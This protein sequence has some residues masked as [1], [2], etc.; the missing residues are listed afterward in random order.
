MVY[1]RNQNWEKPINFL[2]QFYPGNF[3]IICFVLAILDDSSPEKASPGKSIPSDVASTS[4]ETEMSQPPPENEAP[5]NQS[6]KSANQPNVSTNQCEVSSDETKVPASEQQISLHQGDVAQHPETS[7]ASN[8]QS[9][10]SDCQQTVPTG[11]E[12]AENEGNSCVLMGQTGWL[13]GLRC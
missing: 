13:S 10:I 5:Q 1:G 4:Q 6:K 8:I 9:D 12:P 2:Q 7:K 11:L 3:T